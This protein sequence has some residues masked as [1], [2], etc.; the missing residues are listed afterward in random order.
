MNEMPEPVQ[1][2]LRRVWLEDGRFAYLCIGPEGLIQ[3]WHPTIGHYGFESLQKNAAASEKLPFLEGLLPYRE[4]EPFI[5]NA[6][7]F[8]KGVAA[9]IHIL[10]A[11]QKTWVLFFD[12][13]ESLKQKQKLQQDRHDIDLLSRQ[14]QKYIKQLTQ[15]HQ[16]LEGKKKQAESANRAKTR[17]LSYITHDLRTPLTSILSFAQFLEADVFGGLNEKQRDCIKKMLDAGEHMNALI[18]E[19][20]DI[21]QIESGNL[22]LHI[23][24]LPVS[25]LVAECVTWLQPIADNHGIRLINHV[26]GRVKIQADSKRFKQVII[27][28]L[29]NA[30][31]YNR[32]EGCIIISAKV[33]EDYLSI[34]VKDTGIGI[35]DG[36]VEKIFQPFARVLDKKK[37]KDIEGSGVGLSECKQLL[38]L[39][40]GSLGVRSEPGI[41]SVFYIDLPLAVACK[42][43]S[44]Y[45]TYHRLVYLHQDRM[46]FE[47]LNGLL[48]PYQNYRLF[49]CTRDEQGI[50]ECRKQQATLLLDVEEADHPG[51]DERLASLRQQLK[52]VTMVAVLEKSTEAAKIKRILQQGD[53]DDYLLRPFDFNQLIDILEQQ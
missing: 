19:I 46:H 47:L 3:D 7:T 9:D 4:S 30:I 40:G 36:M 50:A 16:E 31:K 12:V 22:E 15:T 13:T 17:L 2:H 27:N 32:E 34:S 6:I 10:Q 14:Q 28:V 48:A 8:P 11:A 25:F 45:R 29:N 24:D 20:L 33:M 53:V 1:L 18:N 44:E 23:E 51:L 26:Q 5:L 38:E 42:G 49:G 21:A 35:A 43:R 37:A 39:M 52:P 41:G